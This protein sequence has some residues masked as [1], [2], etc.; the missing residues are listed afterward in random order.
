MDPRGCGGGPPAPLRPRPSRGGSPRV[1]GRGRAERYAF[2]RCGWIPAGAGEGLR[3]PPAPRSGRVDPRGC[4][5]G[6]F[7]LAMMTEAQGGS[8][9]VRGRALVPTVPCFRVGW[10]PAGAGEGQQ[11]HRQGTE[12][13]VD[14]R[15]C[16][17]GRC[18]WPRWPQGLGGSPRVRGRGA[19]CRSHLGRRGWIPAGA[20]E[21]RPRP[22]P[23]RWGWVDPRG[24]GGGAVGRDSSNR[25]LGGSP[26]VRGRVRRLIVCCGPIRWIPAGAGEGFDRYPDLVDEGVDP[27]GCGGGH[28]SG[29]VPAI[30]RGGSPRVRGRESARSI[31]G[32]VSGW[33]P[34]GAG[35]GLPTASAA[36]ATGVDP[37]GCGGG[38]S[39]SICSP[40]G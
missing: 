12:S 24:C 30:R 17:G 14:P 37:R 20:G 31:V 34:A 11:D 6:E 29:M 22:V 2:A 33:I 35:E 7:E 18:A 39:P 25:Q 27:R 15:W 40:S 32:A 28:G 1:R 9:R 4:G 13:R 19:I 16:G 8:P 36:P 26:R 5:G 10:I 38:I 21:G 23:P 3:G